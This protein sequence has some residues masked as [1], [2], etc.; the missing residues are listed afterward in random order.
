MPLNSIQ[1]SKLAN[2]STPNVVANK[3]S[4]L[5]SK[6]HFLLP[7]GNREKSS[8]PQRNPTETWQRESTGPHS[9]RKK[10]SRAEYSYRPQAEHIEG[11]RYDVTDPDSESIA[12][13]KKTSS[14]TKGSQ[15][16]GPSE[17]KPEG[18]TH[19]GSGGYSESPQ[20]DP[21]RSSELPP[22]RLSKE[23]QQSYSE[24]QDSQDPSTPPPALT[25]SKEQADY[26]D[27]ISPE[28]RKTYGYPLVAN[29][30][31]IP[32]KPLQKRQYNLDENT[33]V[34]ISKS[35]KFILPQTANISLR[36]NPHRPHS[37]A[38]SSSSQNSSQ[39][40]PPRTLSRMN[41]KELKRE[42][43]D[44]EHLRPSKEL[45]KLQQTL[46]EIKHARP[47]TVTAS[48][49][50]RHNSIA[51]VIHDIPSRRSSMQFSE[52][53][54]SRP[55]CSRIHS[56]VERPHAQQNLCFEIYADQYD[57]L[58]AH[59]RRIKRHS[60]S[61]ARSQEP[62]I[63]IT[64][65]LSENHISQFEKRFPPL[66]RFQAHQ[67]LD[68]KI[69]ADQYDRLDLHDRQIEKHL[70]PSAK[71]SRPRAQNIPRPSDNN[72]RLETGFLERFP[73]SHQPSSSSSS[74]SHRPPAPLTL[75]PPQ[76]TVHFEERPPPN[77]LK[78]PR[79]PP[80]KS[81]QAL[82]DKVKQSPPVRSCGKNREKKRPWWKR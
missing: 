35:P 45:E 25:F 10:H 16:S 37:R 23:V 69:Y 65:K 2:K 50:Q 58:D 60:P 22:I 47:Q 21:T 73:I 51:G 78:R 14:Q 12:E 39:L 75:K 28:T 66:E 32:R 19:I 33:K 40:E 34:E 11:W 70:L 79:R 82:S 48:G 43:S 36:E 42:F 76:R 27:N 15:T 56:P 54:R 53:S 71:S 8:K 5:H 20:A 38:K 6:L 30:F 26:Y 1:K 41:M 81:P 7:E 74:R 68:L 77:T 72:V 80:L 17:K 59:D 67:N 3:Q 63:P 49:I 9:K 44:F 55:G 29:T 64:P 62:E 31:K 18:F 24:T 57:G 52:P 46:K 61:L 13:S 4:W